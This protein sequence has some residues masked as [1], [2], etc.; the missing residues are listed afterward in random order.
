MPRRRHAS[1]RGQ[2]GQMRW[3]SVPLTEKGARRT[4]L[5]GTHRPTEAQRHSQ[6]H[7]HTARAGTQAHRNATLPI[8]V[9]VRFPF[10]ALPCSTGFWHHQRSPTRSM[11]SSTHSQT[12]CT[13]GG[14][15]ELMKASCCSPTGS[16]SPRLKAATGVRL[17][18]MSPFPPHATASNAV[19]P[20]SMCRPQPLSRPLSQ[21]WPFNRTWDP[22]WVSGAWAAG[23]SMAPGGRG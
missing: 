14:L 2:N 12:I 9:L 5:T 22:D 4:P 10:V 11:K 18:C 16:Y 1:R 21:C 8:A 19:L 6:R 20:D 13:H 23:F 7:R 15:L 17:R 3:A